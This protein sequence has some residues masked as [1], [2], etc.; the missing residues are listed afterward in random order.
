VRAQTVTVDSCVAFVSSATCKDQLARLCETRVEVNLVTKDMFPFLSC[1]SFK[2]TSKC[3][4][5]YI[6]AILE[7]YREGFER[8]IHSFM[9]YP[10]ENKRKENELQSY[11]Q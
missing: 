1:I 3:P 9:T 7:K 2:E 11:H 5:A 10:K 4:Q 8:S 6:L